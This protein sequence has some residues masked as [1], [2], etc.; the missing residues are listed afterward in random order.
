MFW[1]IIILIVLIALSGFFSGTEVALVSVSRIKARTLLKQNRRGSQSLYKLKEDPHRM[2]ITILIGNNIVNVSAAAL[3]TMTATEYFGS[4][5]IG[6]ATGVIT[7]LILVFGE[8]TPK[9]FAST[10]AEKISLTVAKPIWFLSKIFYPLIIIFDFITEAIRVLFR[11]K[12]GGSSITEEELKTMIEFSAEKKV[13]DMTEKELL[14]G[15]LEFDD[16]TA[17][18]VMR[19]KK[20]IFTINGNTRIKDS[21][22]VIKKSKYSRIPIFSSSRNKI[23]GIVHI[24]DILNNVGKRKRLKDIS[25]EPVLVSGSLTLNEVFKIFQLRQ[26]HMAIVVDS[27]KSTIGLVTLEDLMEEI[28][29]EI[30]DEKDLSP[31][32]I[33]RIDKYTIVVHGETDI[34]RINNFFNIN[35]PVNK[36][37]TRI[38]ELLEVVLKKPKIGSKVSIDDV[39]IIVDDIKNGKI[40]KLRI[41]KKKRFF[42]RLEESLEKQQ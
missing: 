7:F 22:K 11:I 1:N 21:I 17:A 4:A 27:K 12:K 16:I 36:K 42:E 25:T 30:M 40:A 33:I 38:A 6:I 2:I 28:V 14:K 41:I 24:R 13:I 10:H 19:P 29:G 37:Q 23:T 34:E 18:E 15:V 3:A 8:I 32:T 5:G 9:T 26:T 35:L 31:S 20:K 39:N